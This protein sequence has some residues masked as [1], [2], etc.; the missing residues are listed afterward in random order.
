MPARLEMQ[1]GKVVVGGLNE[2]L[3]QVLYWHIEGA[4]GTAEGVGIRLCVV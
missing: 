4:C 1:W 3:G 2:V